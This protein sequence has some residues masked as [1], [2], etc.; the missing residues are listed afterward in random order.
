MSN[1]DGVI[2]GQTLTYVPESERQEFR[3]L[4]LTDIRRKLV[5]DLD[6]AEERARQWKRRCLEIEAVL[7]DFVEENVK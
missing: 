6:F 4:P 2:T 7:G 5:L 3:N 1:E